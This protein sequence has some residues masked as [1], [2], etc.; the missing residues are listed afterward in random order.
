MVLN[1]AGWA[2]FNSTETEIL[3]KEEFDILL[4]NLK[5]DDSYGLDSETLIQAL[6]DEIVIL[7]PA[8]RRPQRENAI[9]RTPREA[10]LVNNVRLDS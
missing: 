1:N 8:A 6:S 3:T 4:A 10:T 5:T 2:D 9:R 7:R